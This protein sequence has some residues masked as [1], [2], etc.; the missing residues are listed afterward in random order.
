M[1]HKVIDVDPQER[2]HQIVEAIVAERG[3]HRS[4]PGGPATPD[5]RPPGRTAA[6]AATHSA[7][8]EGTSGNTYLFEFE[9]D[10]ADESGAV[11]AN[12]PVQPSPKA[13]NHH[14]ATPE[15][16]S[17]VRDQDRQKA[18]VAKV[19]THDTVWHMSCSVSRRV[20]EHAVF[21]WI[22]VGAFG[23]ALFALLL[24]LTVKQL[25]GLLSF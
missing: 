22:A 5:P 7:P 3:A 21:R 25:S 2:A 4:H 19:R 15:E 1:S 16:S 23:A 18:S 24:M 6:E 13:A 9:R 20:L 11:T 12:T 14:D 10:R 17:A 8:E